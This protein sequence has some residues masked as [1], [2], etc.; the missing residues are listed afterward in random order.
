VSNKGNVDT[1]TIRI[2]VA[3]DL[4]DAE[5]ALME[6]DVTS[7][8]YMIYGSSDFILTVR[9]R[10]RVA[11]SRTETFYVSR[12][13][14]VHRESRPEFQFIDLYPQEL[15]K[16]ADSLFQTGADWYRDVYREHKSDLP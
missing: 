1:Q 3:Y 8:P 13:K 7:K 16:E 9:F 14:I 11:L 12:S 4:A 5:K 2:D 10:D 6:L 15:L